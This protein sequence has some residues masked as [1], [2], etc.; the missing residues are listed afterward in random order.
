MVGGLLR[1]ARL[2]KPHAAWRDILR[3]FE[4][5]DLLTYASAIAFQVLFALVPLAL[6]TL[7]LL[8]AFGLTHVWADDLAPQVRDSASPEA[9]KLIDTTVRRVLDHQQLFWI[10]LGALIAVWKVSG[11]MRAVM[12]VLNRI[13]D[14]E[15]ERSF[16]QRFFLSLWLSG[17]VTVMLLGAATTANAVP[18]L[19]GG[20]ILPS[21]AGW[22]VTL[23][24]LLATVAVTVRFGPACKRP[25]RWVSF[26]SVIVIVGWV[27]ASLVFEWYVTDVADYGS[28]FGSLAVLMVALGYLYLSATV[29]VT[30]L[31]LDSLVR[32]EVEPRDAGLPAPTLVVARTLASA[33]HEVGGGA[34]GVGVAGD[35]QRRHDRVAPGV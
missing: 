22:A 8:G 30:G 35:Q 19:L 21:L 17:L 16:K 12:G 1:H 34:D 29:F 27:I 10:T 6:L 14:V 23:A 9:Y 28:V 7:G 20:G 13:Y 18:R 2:L 5:N 3:E 4:R 15:D 33:K 31:Q 25:M 11:A 26:G 32:G 24:L